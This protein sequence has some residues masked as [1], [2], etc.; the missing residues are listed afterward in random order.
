MV[1]RGGS[2]FPLDSQIGKEAGDLHL[3]QMAGL[4]LSVEEDEAS[5]PADV[6]ILRPTAVVLHEE[7]SS[8]FAEKPG[9]CGCWERDFAQCKGCR[10]RR[11]R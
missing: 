9:L 8:G 11:G 1:L 5:D 2:H 4:A 7:R 6:G 10:I 3:D